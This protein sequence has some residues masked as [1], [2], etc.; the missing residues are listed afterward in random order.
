M[1]A[2]HYGQ[3]LYRWMHGGVVEERPAEKVLEGLGYGLVRLW[4]A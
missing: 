4:E 1:R 3:E 2:M